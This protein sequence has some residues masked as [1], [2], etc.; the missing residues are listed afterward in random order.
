MQH[1]V[2]RTLADG[3]VIPIPDV[4]YPGGGGGGAPDPH[5]STHEDAGSDEIDVTD[6]SGRLA[7]DQPFD[8]DDVGSTQGQVLYRGASAWAPLSPGTDGQLLATQG[9]AANPQWVNRSTILTSPD[10]EYH[11]DI[12]P[13]SMVDY[14]SWAGDTPRKTWTWN[15]QRNA[16]ETIEFDG[17]RLN[18]GDADVQI[19]ARVGN[20]T[21]TGTGDM[22]IAVKF[23]PGVLDG[24]ATSTVRHRVGV[25]TEGTVANPTE[26]WFISYNVSGSSWLAQQQSFRQTH[27]TNAF[28][29]TTGLNVG[30]DGFVVPANAV[31]TPIYVI[32]SWDDDNTNNKLQFRA[33]MDGKNWAIVRGTG[34][35][36]ILDSQVAGRPLF[37]WYGVCGADS[38]ERVEWVRTFDSVTTTV[39]NRP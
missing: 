13:D 18:G 30:S 5:A 2:K 23:S 3:R 24:I 35:N 26:I 17:A 25:I 4:S 29:S 39:G 32:I 14:E 21:L 38:Q 16:T 12:P 11:P 8:L 6:L 10:G 1:H 34:N 15:N 9:A 33:C 27:A 28:T 37:F 19:A 20:L 22:S 31:G 36:P 7:D